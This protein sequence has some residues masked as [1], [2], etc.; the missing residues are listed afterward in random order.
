MST[1]SATRLQQ[2]LQLCATAQQARARGQFQQAVNCFQQAAQACPTSTTPYEGL[3]EMLLDQGDLANAATVLK[4]TPP[5]LYRQSLA[6]QA[7]H[8]G[9]LLRQEKFAEAEA[10]FSE[11]ASRPGVDRARIQFNLGWC[12]LGRNELAR[13][14]ECFRAAWMAGM[15]DAAPWISQGVVLQ[16]QGD[17]AAALALYADAARHFP[18]HSDLRYEEALL[19]LRHGDYAAGFALFHH[20]L[21]ARAA[22]LACKTIP[23]V[24]RWNGRDRVARLLVLGEQGIGDQ[25]V[26][27]ALLPGLRELADAVAVSFDVRLNGLLQRSFP[28][29]GV[30]DPKGRSVAEISAGHDAYVFA[31]DI[32]AAT[33]AGVGWQQGTLQP[34]PVLAETFREKYRARFPGKKLVGISWKSPKAKTGAHKSIALPEWKKILETA[35]CQFVSLQY[36]EVADDLLAVKAQLGIDVFADPDADGVA[37]LEALAAQCA[38]LDLVITI[39]NTTA[40][41]AAAQGKPAWVLLPPVN[42]LFWYWG[43]QGERTRWYPAA[44]L[45]RARADGQWQEA[46]DAVAHHLGQMP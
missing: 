35:D 32:G 45:F 4:V 24:P 33:L 11:L 20:R 22:A 36:G 21:R 31:G 6:L 41:I 40:H 25:I 28:G 26:Y 15:N 14:L 1:P 7:L 9:F 13:A 27:S 16:R 12:A 37:S 17:V 5:A 18:E 39:S 34:D 19:R 30:I 8:A 42:G 2:C 43:A 46:L 10:L 3:L 23:P 29:I 44:R 38:A